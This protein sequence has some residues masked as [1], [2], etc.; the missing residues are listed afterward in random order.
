MTTQ[1]PIIHLRDRF[2]AIRPELEAVFQSDAAELQRVRETADKLDQDAAR[3]QL[4]TLVFGHYNAGKSTFINALLGREAAPMGDVPLTARIDRYEW[5]GHVL[6]DSP[7]IDAPIEHEAV[8]DGFIERDCN[9]VIYVIATGGGIEEAATWDRLCRFVGQKKAVLVVVNDKSGFD[10][11]GADFARIRSTVYDNMQAA[12]RK[13]CLGDPLDRIEVL[14]VKA[15]TALKA[16]LEGKQGLLQKSGILEAEDVLRRFLEASTEKILA[17]DRE[18]ARAV[19]NQAIAALSSQAGGE[20]GRQLAVCRGEIETERVRLESALVESVRALAQR[21]IESLHGTVSGIG[22][23]EGD[24]AALLTGAFERSQA[25]LLT[26]VE[27]QLRSEL[28]RSEAVVRRAT[29]LLKSQLK[30]A[31]V[32]IAEVE[33]KAAMAGGAGPDAAGGDDMAAGILKHVKELP[34]GDWTENGVKILL[35][36]GKEWFPK[37]FKGIGPKTMGRWAGVAGK[38]AGPLLMV[39]QSGYELYQAH[40][41]EERAREQHRQFVASVMSTV[42]QAFGD[43]VEQYE[44]MF[45]RIA[46]AALDPVLDALDRQA[47]ALKTVSDANQSTRERLAAWTRDIDA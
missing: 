13:L 18:R 6:Y 24:A 34:V 35:K 11:N 15:R 17:S 41:E 22:A 30:L 29:E 1:N 44:L 4:S 43:A 9:A 28:E 40:K 33:L 37:L 32:D 20:A 16:R 31:D 39:L 38:A 47:L 7:G 23:Q 42:R 5:Q 36:Q 10:L 25:R 14:H 27:K 26:G 8:T 2:T 46:K 45:K 19:V 12:T 3:G 21:E